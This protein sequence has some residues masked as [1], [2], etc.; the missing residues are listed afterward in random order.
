MKVLKGIYSECIISKHIILLMHYI[1]FELNG[2]WQLVLALVKDLHIIDIAIYIGIG[3]LP[4][5]KTL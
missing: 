1:S 5:F 2:F 3:L 4:S